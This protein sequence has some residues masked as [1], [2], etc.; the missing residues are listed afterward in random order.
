MFQYYKDRVPTNLL[1]DS[2]SNE[3]I[4]PNS[5]EWDHQLDKDRLGNLVP[6]HANINTTRSN[7]HLSEYLKSDKGGNFRRFIDILP[8]DD[9]YNAIVKHEDKQDQKPMIHNN[10]NYDAMCRRNEELY[11]TTFLKCLYGD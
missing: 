5:S 3:H 6:I 11:K 9:T 2:F 10:E 1:H 4:I 7:N 8:D